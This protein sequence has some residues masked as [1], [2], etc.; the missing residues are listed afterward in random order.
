MHDSQKFIGRHGEL[1][2]LKA[3]ADQA[4][5]Q[6]ALVYGRRR[7][8][9]SYLLEEFTRNRPIIFY[10][11]T[12]QAE[13]AEL[14]SF[15][16][17]AK[18]S[19]GGEFL[20]PGYQFPDWETALGFIV[21]HNRH[22]RLIIVLDE[23]PYLVQS[24]PAL[25]S[26]IQRWWDKQ[27][28][29]SS[30]MLVLCGS[31]QTFMESLEASA[32]PL[33]GRFTVRLHVGALGFREAGLFT[34]NLSC[35]DKARVYGILG[36]TPLYL[37]QWDE[38]ASLRDNLLRLFSGPTSGLADAAELV[39]TTDLPDGKGSYRALQAVGIGK[40]RFSEIRD[41]AKIASER[42]LQRLVKL[43]FLERRIPATE[44]A[45]RSK[46]SLYV[47]RDPYFRFFFRFIAR[48][49]GLIDRGLGADIIDTQILPFF[50]GHMGG[51]FEDMARDHARRLMISRRLPG[52]DVRS[53][54]STD[55]KHEIDLVGTSN[56]TNVSFIG[57]VKWREAP[58]D[59]KVLFDLEEGA[60]T[61]G[62]PTTVPRLVIGRGNVNAALA[63]IPNAIGASVEDMYT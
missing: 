36:G 12:Q 32:A 10:Q 47:I 23:F 25:P 30:V 8:G 14:Q 60:R 29:T 53:W 48:N 3:A 15:T 58:L 26:M 11:A 56:V 51:I 55:G 22:S 42:I 34:P 49:R 38:S 46:R 7:I 17:A 4:G 54:W 20:P 1:E 13:Q 62:A 57:S 50:D 61:L 40:N 39:L 16:K 2:N 59:M 21:E 9:K 18:E 37:K 63:V 5:G 41:W 27:G 19:V 24:A 44:D 31:A 45:F 33:Y 35:A 52:D 28:R 6:L 43:E